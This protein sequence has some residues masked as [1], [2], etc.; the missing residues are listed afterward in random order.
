MVQSYEAAGEGVRGRQGVS[1]K[2]KTESRCRMWLAE[3]ILGEE[4]RDLRS[5]RQF[6]GKPHGPL[7]HILGYLSLIFSL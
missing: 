7:P 3:T 4:F 5:P 2:L 6:R 1:G